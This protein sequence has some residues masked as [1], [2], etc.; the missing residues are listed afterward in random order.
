MRLLHF[1]PFLMLLAFAPAAIAYRFLDPARRPPFLIYGIRWFLGLLFVFSGLAKLIPH[2]PN[3]MGPPN[4]E[5][6]LAP[7]GL[8][9]YG[10]FIAV[11]EVGTG[12]LLLTRRFAT[13]GALMLVPILVSI[14]V[15][16][17][18]LAWRGTPYVVT[19][20]LGLAAVLLVYDWPKLA[21]LL[22]DRRPAPA[23]TAR[24]LATA[25]G[26]LA[27]LGVVA[28]GLGVVRL[29]GAGGVGTWV[30]LGAL[31]ALIVLDYRAAGR[32]D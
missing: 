19:V 16:T 2:F 15:V 5:A 8:A 7:H 4:L 28:A 14:L 26:W 21:G 23:G 27:G 10:R 18:S 13:L 9:A 29:T 24:R 6:T 22:E 1:P 11:A 17:W 31:V 30:V 25:L 3:T 20:F 12:F 32:P